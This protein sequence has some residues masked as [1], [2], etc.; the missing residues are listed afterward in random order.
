MKLLIVDDE[1]HART[2]VKAYL[3][4]DPNIS[5]IEECANGFEAVK[6]INEQKPDIVILDVE[7]PKLNGFEMLEL[8]EHKPVIIFSTA[9]DE[10]AVKAFENNAAD[11]LLK[12]YSKSRFQHALSKA[13]EK[14]ASKTADDY[15]KLIHQSQVDRKLDRVAVKNA[16]EI[17]IIN[18]NE[19]LFIEAQDDYVSYHLLNGRKYLKQN[20]MKYLENVL[21]EDQFVRVHRSYF[22][23]LNYIVRLEPV[24]KD[25]FL[26]RL[27]SGQE[28]PVSRSGYKHL[29]DIL[30][31]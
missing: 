4:D 17:V 9:Y 14:V 12:P 26:L 28:I 30:E 21:P 1:E 2:L 22:A 16:H 25:T 11:Y 18:L 15:E 31:I 5:K 10:Y 6:R 20:T 27:K 7:M 13:V 19:I 29:K 23:N 8:I 3:N 24:T